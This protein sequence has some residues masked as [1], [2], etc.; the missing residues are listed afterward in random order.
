MSH[1]DRY[2][3]ERLLREGDAVRTSLCTDEETGDRV[4]HK[5]L[6]ASD[7]NAGANAAIER[8]TSALRKLSIDDGPILLDA[9]HETKAREMELH[10]VRPWVEGTSLDEWVS[11]ETRPSVD[12]VF[13]A[14]RRVA[15]TLADL[16]SRRPPLLHGALKPSNMVRGSEGEVRLV[17]FGVGALLAR[18]PSLEDAAAGY[19]APELSDDGAGAESD[20][21]AL[22]A[23]LVALL[24]GR[25]P[26]SHEGGVAAALEELE[27]PDNRRRLL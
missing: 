13:D 8:D 14:G 18:D 21:Y 24:G 25:D 1:A 20:I 10:L 17:D 12:D 4:V 3:E 11:A 7:A 16:H 9:W 26:G 19:H 6:V 22:G 27:L 2:R 5:V 23:S 15:L